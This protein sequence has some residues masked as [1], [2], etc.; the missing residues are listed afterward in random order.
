MLS[1]Y[2]VL[3]LFCILAA[4]WFRRV[5]VGGAW[6]ALL[7]RLCLFVGVGLGKVYG[8]SPLVKEWRTLGFGLGAMGIVAGLAALDAAS[9][10]RTLRVLVVLGDAS[11]AIYLLHI[12]AMTVTAKVLGRVA[13]LGAMRTAGGGGGGGG[14]APPPPRPPT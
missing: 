2:N 11:Y 8:Y 10:I 6:I 7:A 13:D 3:F 1:A 12:M 9:R 14:R 4:L 5:T